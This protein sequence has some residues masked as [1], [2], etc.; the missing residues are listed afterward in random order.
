MAEDRRERTTLPLGVPFGIFAIMA[1]VVFLFSRILL[2]VPKQVAVA[3]ALMTALN[4]AFIPP[5]FTLPP[6]NATI[7]FRNEDTASHSVHIFDGDSATA[8]SLFAGEIVPAGG[9]KTYTV[10]GL[11]A[12]STY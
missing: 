6:G 10:T 9:S 3:V 11:K 5:N 2:N 12:G 7:D 8:P 1:I 4:I